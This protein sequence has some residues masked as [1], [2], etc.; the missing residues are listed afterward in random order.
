MLCEI[1][2]ALDSQKRYLVGH[3]ALCLYI[4]YCLSITPSLSVYLFP[5]SRY[6]S[7]LSLLLLIVSLS[8]AHNASAFFWCLC[9]LSAY[10]QSLHLLPLYLC[11][12]TYIIITHC[13]SVSYSLCLSITSHLCPVTYSLCRSATYPSV[14]VT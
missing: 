4:T 13:V 9:Q 5:I 10:F 8:L 2:G 11:Y 12:V 1:T 6:H 14:S 3:N 7:F